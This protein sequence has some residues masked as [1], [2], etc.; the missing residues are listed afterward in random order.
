MGLYERNLCPCGCGQPV[1]VSQ[2][3]RNRGLFSK[4]R[5]TCYAR[6]ELERGEADRKPEPGELRLVEFD[7]DWKRTF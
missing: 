2:D 7:L 5:V 3:E 4:Q 1:R 6:A